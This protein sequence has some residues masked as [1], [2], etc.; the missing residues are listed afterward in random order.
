[1]T[2]HNNISQSEQDN[3][4]ESTVSIVCSFIVK[5]TKIRHFNIQ[6]LLEKQQRQA[7]VTGRL[8]LYVFIYT[9]Q[10]VFPY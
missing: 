5:K 2:V 10:Y 1:M 3:I 9:I 7:N 4:K 8:N 6:R